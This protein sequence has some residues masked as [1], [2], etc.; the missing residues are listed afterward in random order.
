MWARADGEQPQS[1]VNFDI[2]PQELSGALDAFSRSSGMAVLVDR[3]LTRGRR[4]IGVQGRLTA[5]QALNTLLVGTGLMAR[6]ARADAFTLQVAQVA[7]VP[8]PAGAAA[9][10]ASQVSSSYALAIQSAIERRLCRSVLT[11][12]GGYR[13]LLQVWIG[14]DGAV[15]HSRLVTSSGDLQRDAALVDSVQHLRIEQLPPSSL[16]QP[17]TL[18]LVPQSSG[19]SMECTQWEGVSGG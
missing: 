10:A 18:L 12:P 7:Q 3:Q 11:R 14:R 13:A 5:T 9:N 6:Y 16:R 15:Q 4:S 19:K 1:W 8:L 2:A 17:V